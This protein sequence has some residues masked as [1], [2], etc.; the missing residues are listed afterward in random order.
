MVGYIA[1]IVKGG[2]S[3]DLLATIPQFPVVP[4]SSHS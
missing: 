4:S 3:L 2:F 1:Q